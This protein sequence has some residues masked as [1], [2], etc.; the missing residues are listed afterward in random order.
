MG[1]KGSFKLFEARFCNS[2]CQNVLGPIGAAR[3]VLAPR[4]AG[5]R[6]AAGQLR[7]ANAKIHTSYGA[8]IGQ[9]QAF[10]AVSKAGSVRQQ[11]SRYGNAANGAA[12]PAPSA[13]NLSYLHMV[14]HMHAKRTFEKCMAR[15]WT[16][17]YFFQR[18]NSPHAQNGKE[19]GP[20]AKSSTWRT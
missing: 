18:L 3:A 15:S 6:R 12:S 19:Q 10:K 20:C 1:S 7:Q 2:R 5:A 17:V 9:G 14:E 13:T 11:R 4:G 8:P 16:V